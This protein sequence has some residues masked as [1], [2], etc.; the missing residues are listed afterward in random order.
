MLN[1]MTVCDAYYLFACDWH[2]GQWSPEYR[3]LGRLHNMGFRP[4]A[5]L[6]AKKLEPE[7]RSLLARLI[8][9]ARQGKTVGR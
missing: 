8:R 4:T 1:R 9:K 2:K 7:G 5:N 6:T 3:I